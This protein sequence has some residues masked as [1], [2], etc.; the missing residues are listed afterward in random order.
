[1]LGIAIA[2]GATLAFALSFVVST[3]VGSITGLLK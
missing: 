2:V 1:L 3:A